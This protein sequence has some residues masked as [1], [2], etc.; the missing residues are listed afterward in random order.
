MEGCSDKPSMLFA[1]GS[2]E[3]EHARLGRAISW[4]GGIDL[5]EDAEESDFWVWDGMVGGGACD[6]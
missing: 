1:C 6:G 3:R 2:D 5:D 4:A